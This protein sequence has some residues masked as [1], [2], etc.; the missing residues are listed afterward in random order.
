MEKYCI[1]K[2]K[3]ITPESYKWYVPNGKEASELTYCQWCYQNGCFNHEEVYQ[4]EAKIA[5]ANC[6]CSKEHPTLT[7]RITKARQM[8]NHSP[9]ECPSC[10]FKSQMN[11]GLGFC[12]ASISSCSYCGGYI[13][14][15]S[16]KI[17]YSC[18]VIQNI[19]FEC[20]ENIKTGNEYFNEF[21]E[22][23]QPDEINCYIDDTSGRLLFVLHRLRGKTA[24]QIMDDIINEEL[25]KKPINKKEKSKKYNEK[26][27]RDFMKYQLKYDDGKIEK[28]ITKYNS[29]ISEV[30]EKNENENENNSKIDEDI[31]NNSTP[32]GF[33][34]R[35]LGWKGWDHQ[36]F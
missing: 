31:N 10:Y 19:C 25:Y 21:W 18:C 24:E 20:N 6:D 8:I 15:S 9:F 26:I 3:F 30:E 4:M 5:N 7:Q 35:F 1:G 2:D 36:W 13:H 23:F 28:E 34:Q 22:K 14:S 33:I 17:C 32:K 29:L 16:Y 27:G 11:C 12:T